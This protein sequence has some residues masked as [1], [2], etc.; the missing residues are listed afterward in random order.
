MYKMRA[1]TQRTESWV[2]LHCATASAALQ[3]ALTLHLPLT[4][5]LSCIECIHRWR[6][7]TK[8]M[9]DGIAIAIC[10][11]QLFL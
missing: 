9:S 3:H 11:S 1:T 10:S 6:Y 8:F 4:V 2:T 5:V 7:E